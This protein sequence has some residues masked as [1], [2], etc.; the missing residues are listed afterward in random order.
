MIFSSSQFEEG[1]T[2]LKLAACHRLAER[3]HNRTDPGRQLSVGTV[4]VTQ[5]RNYTWNPWAEQV[6]FIS[7]TAQMTHALEKLFPSLSFKVMLR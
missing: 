3:K 5:V 1:N 6:Q 4:S 2:D 7:K